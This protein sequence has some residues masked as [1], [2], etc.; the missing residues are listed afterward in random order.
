M[1]EIC[2]YIICTGGTE[3]IYTFTYSTLDRFHQARR[4][5]CR[6]SYQSQWPSP[7]NRN[8]AE[9]EN[10]PVAKIGVHSAYCLELA[11]LIKSNQI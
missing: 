10:R 4:F 3:T 9:R 8:K 2:S 1:E 11:V 7:Y 5:Y 6:R